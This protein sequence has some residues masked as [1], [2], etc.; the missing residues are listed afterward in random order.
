MRVGTYNLQGSGASQENKWNQ[1]IKPLLTGGLVHD[2]VFVQE[3][4]P[5]PLSCRVPQ[6]ISLY[7]KKA[8]DVSKKAK[9]ATG[10]RYLKFGGSHRRK[11]RARANLNL[12]HYEWDTGSGRVNLAVITRHKAK[13]AALLYPDNKTWRPALGLEIDGVWYFS[14]HAISPKGPDAKE[15]LGVV[16]AH[17]AQHGAGPWV[18]GGDF[19]REPDTMAGCLGTIC[20]AP[21][22]THPRET[23]DEKPVRRIYDYV[24]RNGPAR[25]GVCLNLNYSDHVAVSYVL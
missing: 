14:I 24:V 8:G 11:D 1:A 6:P 20:P 25:T 19:N 10:L 7:V 17:V 12:L 2:V 9:S 13:K 18:V 23:T 16:H 15:L 4:G 22:G 5:V 21:S 3:A